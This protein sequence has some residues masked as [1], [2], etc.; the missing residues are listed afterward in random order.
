MKIT[1]DKFLTKDFEDIFYR[2][3]DGLRLYAR[4]YD[5]N[6]TKPVVLCMHGLTRN[7][8]DFH[9]L[10]LHL[11]DDFRVISVD[12]RG[13]GR[14]AYDVDPANYRPDLYCADMLSLLTYLGLEQVIAIGTSM[15]GIMA[16]M[17][18][19]LKSEIFS[20][21]I[22]NDIGPE[23]DPS[24][25]ARIK[26]YVGIDRPF[27]NWAAAAAAVKAQ[28]PEIFPDYTVEDWAAFAKRTCFELPD[29]RVDFAYDPA[30]SNPIQNDGTV[31]EPIDMWT[32]F[33]ALNDIPVLAIRGELSDLL[34]SSTLSKMSNVHPNFVAVEIPHVGHA[35]MLTE[36]TSLKA[37]DSF[38]R[39]AS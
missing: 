17:M 5:P 33:R 26:G 6:S 10:A 3:K 28:G 20:K 27:N 4:D 13:R 23:I 32:M 15:G 39:V 29:G 24:G 8:S 38:L 1:K 16:M 18:V 21:V 12:Q 22:L 35:P 30:I 7:S 19:G 34:S 37:I 25:L 11:K 14:S 2:S 36:P 31:T 9:Q